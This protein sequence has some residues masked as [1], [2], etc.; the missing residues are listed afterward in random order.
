MSRRKRNRSARP[1]AS[2]FLQDCQDL[3]VTM[4][5]RGSHHDFTHRTVWMAVEGGINLDLKQNPQ[6]A[7]PLTPQTTPAFQA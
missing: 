3:E 5:P 4:L 2:C 6:G 7:P 1:R